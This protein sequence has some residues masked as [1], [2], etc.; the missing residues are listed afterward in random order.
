MA[1]GRKTVLAALCIFLL[2]AA[3]NA[4]FF[5]P[6]EGKYRDSIE[7]GYASMAR[8]F[9]DHPNPFGWNPYQYLGLPAHDWYLPAV[10]YA[11]AVCIWLLPMLKA[12]HVYRLVVTTA[13]CLGPV[14]LFLFVFYFTRNRKWAIVAA[15]LYTFFSPSYT[16]F[17]AIQKDLG[18]SYVP[19][20]VQALIKYGEGPHNTGLML[21]PLTLI[22]CWHAA[23]RRRFWHVFAA[24]ALLAAISLTN[25]VACLAA[26]WCCLA[27]LIVGTT[28]QH[29][30]GFAPGRLL[31]AALL[32]Y[33]LAAFWLTPGFVQTTMFNWPADAFNYKLQTTQWALFGAVAGILAAGWIFVWWR[34]ARHYHA[35]LAICLVG[36][37]FIV[38][39][40]YWYG[41]DTIPESR[42]YA[43]EVEFFFA[44]VFSEA[45]RWFLAQ[46]RRWVRDAG[47][48][49]FG[50][51]IVL[52]PT[53]ARTYVESTWIQLRPTPRQNTVEYRTAEFLASRGSEG[54]VYLGGGT[55]FRINSWFPVQQVHGTFE[56]GLTNRSAVYFNYFIRT[57]QGGK[58]ERRAA[59][60][61][62]L[63]RAAGVEYLAVHG[64]RSSEHWRDILNPDAFPAALPKVWE[65]G[66][67]YVYRVPFTG[68]AHLVTGSEY[69]QSR[70]LA[71]NATIL[72]CFVKAMD[73]PA[74]RLKFEW[75]GTSRFRIT[76]P[77]PEGMLV[78]TRVAWNK[79]WT[80]TQDG[81]PLH[82]EPDA[83]DLILL[84]P[85]PAAAAV[86]EL[87]YRP[88]F[89]QVALTV[90][91]LLAWAASIALVWRE[92]RRRR[93]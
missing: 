83:M 26:A 36:F 6:G 3:L 57:G 74:R 56:S 34:P 18:I 29:E 23:T 93:A 62:L 78:S 69:P 11:S 82:A 80:G 44:A 9:S 91:S 38:C 45:L 37:A 40:H 51:W 4:P 66:D 58:P 55:R 20:R 61:I 39:G 49:L 72:E 31:G 73:D 59:D 79:G 12:E 88:P 14:T 32:G 35:F 13:A 71:A 90:V 85:K 41:V 46:P 92:R 89:E 86:I 8:F 64:P 70:P 25:W 15:L 43:L 7:G 65:D 33:L 27:M 67:N 68:F 42:R 1:P 5:L 52:W 53:Q 77:V 22:A 19:W 30:H 75:L 10:P 87:A 16:L 2:N 50:V 60:A 47:M 81:A 24:A 17:P 63:M 84:R 54:R 21:L 28:T 76:G 48:A